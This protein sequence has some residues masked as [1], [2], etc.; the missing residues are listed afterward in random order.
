MVQ[1]GYIKKLPILSHS[2]KCEYNEHLVEA[3]IFS[4]LPNTNQRFQ[5]VEYAD[6]RVNGY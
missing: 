6:Y 1:E 4:S 3:G 2:E 5:F